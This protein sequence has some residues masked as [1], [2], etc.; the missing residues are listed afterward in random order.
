[1]ENMDEDGFC[2]LEKEFLD[3]CYMLLYTRKK[4]QDGRN[5]EY[6]KTGKFQMTSSYT[7]EKILYKK[8]KIK[9]TTWAFNSKITFYAKNLYEIAPVGI[10]PY[11]SKKFEII[12]L[13]PYPNKNDLEYDENNK[14]KYNINVNASFA[15][16][17]KN[18]K[19]V[20]TV[21]ALYNIT[22]IN[23]FNEFVGFIN[24]EKMKYI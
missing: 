21:L 17:L 19:I 23:M 7:D 10:Y 15:Y 4:Y 16:P 5:A 18:G 8:R 6:I 3:A 13:R 24:A 22:T 11:C 12:F 14:L 20:E 9:Y 2:K 1:M